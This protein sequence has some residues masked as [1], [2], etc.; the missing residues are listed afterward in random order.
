ML[1]FRFC[2]SIN[3]NCWLLARFFHWSKAKKMENTLKT[4]KLYYI[5]SQRPWYMSLI[6]LALNMLGNDQKIGLVF[7]IFIIEVTFLVAL[8]NHQRKASHE[9]KDIGSLFEDTM[10]RKIFWQRNEVTC[11][12][13]STVG[14]LGQVDVGA[15]FFFSFFNLI[16]VSI[17]SVFKRTNKICK[18]R[19]ILSYLLTEDSLLIMIGFPPLTIIF[20]GLFFRWSVCWDFSFKRSSFWD[21]SLRRLLLEFSFQI[22][23]VLLRITLLSEYLARQTLLFQ[24]CLTYIDL[25]KQN[26]CPFSLSTK[27]C[28]SSKFIYLGIS[29]ENLNFSIFFSSC[30]H[31]LY[32]VTHLDKQNKLKQKVISKIK[33]KICG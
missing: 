14:K 16:Q 31:W 15:N 19:F 2:K 32:F 18:S 11:P 24:Q 7:C 8:T 5:M 23:Q 28:L 29:L 21:S 25:W 1:Q 10:A 33:K 27:E 3:C 6:L 22:N 20:L 26:L 4:Y 17:R 9:R 30:L 12:A 13:E